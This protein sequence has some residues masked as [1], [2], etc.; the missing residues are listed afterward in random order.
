MQATTCTC[1]SRLPFSHKPS[2]LSRAFMHASSVFFTP[3]S[4]SF[5]KERGESCTKKLHFF[6]IV[7][8]RHPSFLFLTLPWY[9]PAPPRRAVVYGA[10]T[11]KKLLLQKGRRGIE[12]EGVCVCVCVCVLGVIFRNVIDIRLILYVLSLRW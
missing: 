4:Q 9:I 2:C 12:Q 8:K 5:V 6:C 11:G 10:Y 7:C 1:I 3:A